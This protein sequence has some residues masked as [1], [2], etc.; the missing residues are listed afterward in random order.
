MR[1]QPH[2]GFRRFIATTASIRFRFGP[3]GPGP[4]L[5]C[6]EN[7]V[8]IFVY[9]AERADVAEWKASERWRKE[10]A[11]AAHEQGAQTGDDPVS[12]AQIGGTSAIAI[13]DQQLV[14]NQR[15]FGNNGAES[16]GSYQ[17]DNGDD[18][19]NEKNEEVAHSWQS[20]Q[21]LK[22]RHSGNLIIRH[23]QVGRTK[24]GGTMCRRV[25]HGVLGGIVEFEGPGRDGLRTANLTRQPLRELVQLYA[26]VN[27]VAKTI[28]VPPQ[29]P[30]PGL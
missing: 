23:A 5:R 26:A 18:Q 27:L 22:S 28:S 2:L 30:L 1:G 6:G 25:A 4:C 10:S 19:M 20:Y 16:A 24:A 14:P 8:G 7:R 13:E 3:F 11:C 15:R 17:P 29:A 12:G 21:H 9:I